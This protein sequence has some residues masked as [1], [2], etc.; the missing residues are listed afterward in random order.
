MANMDGFVTTQKIHEMESPK[1]N[2]LIV[3]LTANAIASDKDE[4]VAIGM[5]DY[6]SKPVRQEQL[7]S[8]LSAI[9][10]P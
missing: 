2:T 4:I 6:L 8:A 5:N 10:A 7:K 3:S 9:G 1:C